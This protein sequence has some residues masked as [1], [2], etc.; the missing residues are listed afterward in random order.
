MIILSDSMDM[1]MDMLVY[2]Q[3]KYSFTNINRLKMI[4]YVYFLTILWYFQNFSIVTLILFLFVRR[5]PKLYMKLT[6]YGIDFRV[7][8]FWLNAFGNVTA[9]IMECGS[10]IIDYH[11][12][13]I[14]SN[15]LCWRKLR[16]FHNV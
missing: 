9:L 4:H 6:H 14:T 15:K 13:S 12:C 11:I 10:G 1:P 2:N 5:E 3:I 16:E 7:I 8:N